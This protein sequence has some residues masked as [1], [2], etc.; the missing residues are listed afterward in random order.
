MYE[1]P[2]WSG[3]DPRPEVEV[4]GDEAQVEGW[5]RAG[6][7]QKSSDSARSTQTAPVGM[8]FSSE[9]PTPLQTLSDSICLAES[10]PENS[11][12]SPS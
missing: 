3:P 7:A 11:S 10:R 9:V 1:G 6:T 12:P 2:G 5:N 8:K 4:E